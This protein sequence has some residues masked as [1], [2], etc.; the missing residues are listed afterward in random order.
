M[1]QQIAW[2]ITL[3]LTTLIAFAFVYVAINSGR[4]EEDYAPL[5]KRAYRARTR[6]FW[7]LVA[8]FVPAM[9]YTLFALPYGAGGA[10]DGAG[11]VQIIQAKSYQWR[12]ELSLDRVA[13]GQAVEFHVTSAD[14]NHGFALYDPD[15]RLVAQTQAMPGYVN[16]VRYTFS[17]SGAYRILCLEYC[18]A[19]HHNMIAEIRVGA[20]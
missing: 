17:R 11:P 4:R 6:L 16:R 2:Q 8:M 20:Q 9:I 10:R 18:G 19:A 7:A 3:V 1:A 13:P 5:Q 15:M 14:V 12:W